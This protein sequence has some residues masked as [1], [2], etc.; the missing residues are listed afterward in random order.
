MGINT[1]R[2][3][4]DNLID[5]LDDPEPI[6]ALAIALT[7]QIDDPDWNRTFPRQSQEIREFVDRLQEA[8]ID[9]M[10]WEMNENS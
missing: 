6:E 4:A 9:R 7:A 5:L 10:D 1:Y 8:L 2:V 3:I